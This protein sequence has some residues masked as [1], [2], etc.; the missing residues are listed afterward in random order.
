MKLIIETLDRPGHA[1]ASHLYK[2]SGYDSSL[3]PAEARRLRPDKFTAIMLQSG[4]TKETPNGVSM[5][6]LLAVMEHHITSRS[7]RDNLHYA[8]ALMH[9]EAARHELE[10]LP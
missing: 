7:D 1:G 8:R 4:P 3:N 6:A 9:M 5:T 2:I 10:Q